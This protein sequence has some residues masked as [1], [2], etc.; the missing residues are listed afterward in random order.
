MTLTRQ[1]A[2][3]SAELIMDGS[4]AGWGRQRSDVWMRFRERPSLLRGANPG[5]LVFFTGAASRTQTSSDRLVQV[6]LMIRR[7]LSAV[8]TE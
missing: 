8:S 1:Q 4:W 3:C 6:A 2:R 5:Y 7:P